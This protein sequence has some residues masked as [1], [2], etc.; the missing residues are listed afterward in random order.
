M[1]SIPATPSFE[2]DFHGDETKQEFEI[3][4]EFEFLNRKLVDLRNIIFQIL[5]GFFPNISGLIPESSVD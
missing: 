4:I 3:E 2:P 1:S 5:I